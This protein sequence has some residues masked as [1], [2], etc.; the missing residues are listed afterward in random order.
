MSTLDEQVLA[1]AATNCA[2]T[3]YL[4]RHPENSP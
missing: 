4:N 2:S 3:D 1:D